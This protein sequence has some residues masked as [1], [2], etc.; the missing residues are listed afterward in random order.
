MSTLGQPIAVAEPGSGDYKVFPVLTF[1]DRQSFS[2]LQGRDLALRD[3]INITQNYG[4]SHKSIST[5]TQNFMRY[6]NNEMYRVFFGTRLGDLE[7]QM[8]ITDMTYIREL[9]IERLTGSENPQGLLFE[10]LPVTDAE[11]VVVLEKGFLNYLTSTKAAPE[12]F[13]LACLRCMHHFKCDK[14]QLIR[15]YLNLKLIEGYHKLLSLRIR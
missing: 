7:H 11:Y 12:E 1:V 13:V 9:F 6:L 4:E 8:D 5:I 2:K 3:F 15:L 14:S 10:I